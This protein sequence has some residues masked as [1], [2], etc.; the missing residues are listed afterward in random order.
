MVKQLTALG[1]GRGKI[2]PCLN[3]EM[4]REKKIVRKRQER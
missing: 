1:R 2:H 3:W 4:M